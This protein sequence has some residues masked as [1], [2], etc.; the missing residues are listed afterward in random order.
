MRAIVDPGATE[1][2]KGDRDMTD[3]R[4]DARLRHHGGLGRWTLGSFTF[5]STR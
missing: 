2:F 1:G 3:G 5:S 4:R